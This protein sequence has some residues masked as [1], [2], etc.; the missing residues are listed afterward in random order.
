MEKGLI[1]IAGRHESLG[2]PVL[3]GT[4][5]VPAG[6]RIEFVEG[7]AGSGAIEAAAVSRLRLGDR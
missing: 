4:T 6:L 5:K 3:Y 7:L 2:R 1:K